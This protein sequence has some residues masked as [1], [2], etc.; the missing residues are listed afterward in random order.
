MLKIK[1]ISEYFFST[2]NLS[3]DKL[4]SSYFKTSFYNQKISKNIPS[5]YSYKPS[6][7][8]INCLVSFKKKKIK[9]ENL[10]LN[11]IWKIDSNNQL[12]FNNLHNFLWLNTLDIKTSKVVTQNIIEYWIEKFN[13]TNS[14]QKKT[15]S[16]LY[17]DYFD[18]DQ[19]AKVEH[20]VLMDWDHEWPKDINGTLTPHFEGKNI[21]GLNPVWNEK[22]SSVS[23]VPSLS[24]NL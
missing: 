7:H 16:T 10:H 9:I 4:R 12:E 13:C 5:K 17:I 8:I 3:L 2:F 14:D 19:G 21:F 1:S 22:Y 15:D 11:S 18:C 23:P 20:Y 24:S 6:P